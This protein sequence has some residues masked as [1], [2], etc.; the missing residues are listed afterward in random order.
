MVEI[1]EISDLNRVYEKGEE[2]LNTIVNIFQVNGFEVPDYR[3]VSI[4]D[5]ERVPHDNTDQLTVGVGDIR[6]YVFDSGRGIHANCGSALMRAKFHV[7]LVRCTPQPRSAKGGHQN[8]APP[9]EKVQEY[10]K[11]RSQEMWLMIRACQAIVED[12]FL[13]RNDFVLA[14]GQD[15][16]GV[17]A[18]KVTLDC[19]V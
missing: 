10:G 15:S 16:G 12:D 3:Y 7:E 4:Y 8:A 17:Q 9:L 2:I 11:A 14:S 1:E 18:I 6:P 5:V 19:V 13:R